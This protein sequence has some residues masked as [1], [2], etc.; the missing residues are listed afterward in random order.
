V[1]TEYLVQRVRLFPELRKAGLELQDEEIWSAASEA[2]AEIMRVVE[3]I[4][5]KGV[6]TFVVGQEIYLATGEG[7]IAW[8]TK[9]RRFRR[10]AFYTDTSLGEIRETSEAWVDSKRKHGSGP[11]PPRF[12]YPRRTIPVS[13]GFWGPTTSELEVTLPFVVRHTT[14]NDLSDT[15]DPLL[16]DDYERCLKLGTVAYL[17]ENRITQHAAEYAAMWKQFNAAMLEMLASDG[18]AV[19]YRNDPSLD[20]LQ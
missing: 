15:V 20:E 10:R 14:D 1:T 18:N 7:A 19:G 4:E 17:F 11:S 2:Q 3:P 9:V 8:L 6:L 12:F 5:D 13:V 16:S